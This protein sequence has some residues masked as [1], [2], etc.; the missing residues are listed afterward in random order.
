MLDK[1]GTMKILAKFFCCLII[2]GFRKFRHLVKLM[3]FMG[4]YQRE[5]MYTYLNYLLRGIIKF[6]FAGLIH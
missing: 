5:I 2:K 1:Y 6:D 4:I 3:L